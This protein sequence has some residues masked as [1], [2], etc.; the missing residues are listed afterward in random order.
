[1]QHSSIQHIYTLYDLEE[2]MKVLKRTFNIVRL[3]SPE[4]C[5]VL[6][7]ERGKL[8]FDGN[9]HTLW[10]RSFPC[11]YCLSRRVVISRNTGMKTEFMDGHFFL[12]LAK[13][14]FWEGKS[15]SL[16]MITEMTSVSSLEGEDLVLDEISRLEKENFRLMHD[17]LTHCYSRHYMNENFQLYVQ[18]AKKHGQE[19]CVALFDMDNF[20]DIND[21]YGH[22]IGDE[23][24][25]SCCQ[26]WLKYFDVPGQSFLTRYGGDEFV[27]VAIADSY[28]DFCSRLVQLSSSM[29]KTIVR[30]GGNSIP[31]S[32]TMGCAFMGETETS[33]AHAVWEALLSLADRRMYHGKSAGRNCILTSSPA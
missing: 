12:V 24:L 21:R 13:Y 1:M 5:Q 16:E 26:F 32:F 20:K 27:I 4:N 10:G 28:Q 2:E 6:R 7:L 18:E 17:P 23:V 8:S 9:C 11:E 30:P 14:V 25:K 22:T 29:R 19:L 3:V 33:D 15:F 31:F